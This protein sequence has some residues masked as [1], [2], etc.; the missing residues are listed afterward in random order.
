MSLEKGE[1]IQELFY[2]VES[3]GLD[4]Y[5]TYIPENSTNTYDKIFV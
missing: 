1:Q 3:M 5:V 4:D 2:D